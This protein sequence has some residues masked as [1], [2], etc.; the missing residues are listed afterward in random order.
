MTC[1]GA[2]VASH[3]GAFSSRKPGSNPVGRLE[4]AHN[5][6]Q[7][8][9]VQLKTPYCVAALSNLHGKSNCNA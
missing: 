6:P 9:N 2:G 1:E 5:T 7:G 4:Q 3:T 8:V